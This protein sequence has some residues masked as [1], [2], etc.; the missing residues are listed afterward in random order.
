M[1][2]DDIIGDNTWIA[3]EFA[4]ELLAIE[5]FNLNNS[6]KKIAV[7]RAMRAIYPDQW[8]VNQI[9]IYHDFQHPRYNYLVASEEQRCHEASIRLRMKKPPNVHRPLHVGQSDPTP[10]D[11]RGA[12]N[13]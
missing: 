12:V 6:T 13:P 9:Y 3:S 11:E 10:E 5:E 1:Y 4:G 8:W 2:F 7:N